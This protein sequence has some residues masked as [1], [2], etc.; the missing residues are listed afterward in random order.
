MLYFVGYSKDLKDQA[1]AF[2]NYSS[3]INYEFKVSKIR[4][5]IRCCRTIYKNII[6]RIIF[7]N[8]SAPTLNIRKAPPIQ[9][10]ENILAI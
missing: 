3:Y 7:Y 1:I 8:Q 2:S 9:I 5:L 4:D 6:A 10:E